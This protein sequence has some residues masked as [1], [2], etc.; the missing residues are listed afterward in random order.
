MSKG[1]VSEIETQPHTEVNSIEELQQLV[2]SL[3]THVTDLE[4]QVDRQGQMTPDWLTSDEMDQVYDPDKILSGLES[5]ADEGAAK[6]MFFGT[7]SHAI[8]KQLLGKFGPKY[9]IKSRVRINPDAVVWG[10]EDKKWRDPLN[11]SGSAGVGIVMKVM[12]LTDAGDWKYRVRIK[13]L[14]GKNGAGFRESELLP[15]RRKITRYVTEE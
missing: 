14:T 5:G 6:I 3:I 4:S 2:A 10:T 7:D 11:E 1:G 8:P 9:F 15:V 13:G 12:H